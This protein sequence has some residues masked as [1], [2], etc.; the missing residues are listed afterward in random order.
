MTKQKI[1]YW[2]IPPKT[3]AEFAAS[4]EE[5]LT[6]RFRRWQEVKAGEAGF[7]WRLSQQHFF[8]DPLYNFLVVR[9]VLA[10]GWLSAWVDQYVVDGLVRAASWAM[11]NDSTQFSSLARWTRRF[12]EGLIDGLVNLVGYAAKGLGRRLRHLQSGQLQRYL[13]YVLLALGVASLYGLW[14]WLR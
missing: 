11:V 3:N 13:M 5:V 12:D 14:T 2:V 7:A 1:A 8:L 9:P 6:R 4:M 10:L